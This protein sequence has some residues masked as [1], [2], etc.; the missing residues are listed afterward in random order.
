MPV[1]RK[2]TTLSPPLPPAFQLA[3]NHIYPLE[4]GG[5]RHGESKRSKDMIQPE[6]RF[7]RASVHSKPS[8]PQQVIAKHE[9]NLLQLQ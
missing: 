8:Q 3:G 4:G 2:I 5:G 7:C 9:T 1:H 6:T